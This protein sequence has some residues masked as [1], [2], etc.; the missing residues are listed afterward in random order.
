MR[1]SRRF[2]ALALVLAMVAVIFCGVTASAASYKSVRGAGCV[3]V[4]TGK[5]PWYA[6][7]SSPQITVRNTGSKTATIL[8]ENER[9]QLVK[10]VTALKAGKSSTISLGKNQTFTVLYSGHYTVGGGVSLDI[11]AKR[12][13][14][15]IR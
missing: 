10:Q 14:K 13:I 12:Y 8:V 4:E 2:L 1:K 15:S 11:S 3:T 6:F 5:A 9:G 7:F